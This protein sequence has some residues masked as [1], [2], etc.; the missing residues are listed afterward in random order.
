[1]GGSSSD[2]WA[3]QDTGHLFRSTGGAF[4][5]VFTM[6]YGAKALYAKNNTVVIVQTRS[7]RTCPP[8]NNCTV[9]ASYETFALL[10]SGANLNL[11][12][13]AACGQAA[14]DITVVVSDVNNMAGLIHWDGMTWTRTN[15]NLGIR[16]PRACFYDSA[17]RLHVVG[18]DGIAI[19]EEGAITIEPITT[20]LTNFSG[21]T[22]SEGQ[23]FAV[24][25]NA[26]WRKPMGGT[27]TQFPLPTTQTLHVAVGLLPNELYMLGYF[28]ST[29]GSGWK[30]NGTT[31]VAAGTT[32]LPSTGSQSL[33]RTSLVTSP[34]EFFLGGSNTA[35]P[36][37]VRARR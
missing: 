26:L 22:L 31:F 18:E 12:G 23:Y 5:W 10:N 35:G 20:N 2:L 30:W 17:G 29:N 36:L 4:N 6:Q 8:T 15:A 16:Y 7:I 25:Y 3:I 1:L 14:N 33:I 32:L 28:N 19:E 34:T 27:W 13:E 11:F 37:I 9:E 21:T 24:G